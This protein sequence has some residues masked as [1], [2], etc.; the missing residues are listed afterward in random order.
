M[1]Q[2]GDTQQRLA[3]LLNFIQQ[4]ADSLFAAV[5]GEEA[6]QVLSRLGDCSSCRRLKVGVITVLVVTVTAGVVGT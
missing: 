1:Q 3:A 4:A 5:A 6:Q 2:T